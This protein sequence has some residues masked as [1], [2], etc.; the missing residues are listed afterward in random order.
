MGAFENWNY[1]LR[2]EAF[3][4][5]WASY[6]Y[7]D[8]KPHNPWY[9]DLGQLHNHSASQHIWRTTRWHQLWRRR[10][11]WGSKRGHCYGRRLLCGRWRYILILLLLLLIL[12]D[13]FCWLKG[14]RKTTRMNSAASILLRESQTSEFRRIKEVASKLETIKIFWRLVNFQAAIS[15]WLGHQIQ[16]HQWSAHQRSF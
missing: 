14:A 13:I 7:P 16:H 11:H 1:S 2:F 6:M 8:D 10:L 12:C 9:L 15:G 3:W 5:S 4:E